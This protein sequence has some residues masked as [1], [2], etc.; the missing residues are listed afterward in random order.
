MVDKLL[1]QEVV[2]GL[3]LVLMRRA[4]GNWP[5]TSE[6]AQKVEME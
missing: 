2:L 5:N 6:G 3:G 4:R 1:D